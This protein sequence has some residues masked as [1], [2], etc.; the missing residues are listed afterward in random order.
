MLL[1]KLD[2]PLQ[3][4]VELHLRTPAQRVLYLAIAAITVAD[5]YQ[6]PIRG[7]RHAVH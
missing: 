5:L 1:V 6:L 7:K 2:C 4:L 3:A